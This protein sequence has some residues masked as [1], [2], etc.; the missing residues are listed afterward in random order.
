MNKKIKNAERT[1]YNDIQFKSD[2]E[3]KCYK[4]LSETEG[5][6]PKYEDKAF[7]LLESFK[8]TVDFWRSTK[9]IP[10]K[11]SKTRIQ[12]WTYTPDFIVEYKNVYAIIEV[13][14]FPNDVYPVK[15]KLFRR[16]LEA[17][18]E[19]NPSTK[20]IFF[21]VKSLRELRIAIQVIKDAAKEIS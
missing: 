18:S 21:E 10:F 15:K 9:R 8:P 7:V 14:G 20:F 11:I 12:E 2:I 5:F 6:N 4:L 16:I 17:I 13:K 1:V 3:M 19:G